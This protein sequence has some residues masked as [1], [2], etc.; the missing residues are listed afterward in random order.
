M[1]LYDSWTYTL[2]NSGHGVTGMVENG[3]LFAR[4]TYQ[5]YAL[6]VLSLVV[7]LWFVYYCFI[8]EICEY[9]DVRCITMI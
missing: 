5:S 6:F 1:L 4:G 8:T 2:Y 9:F 7:Y 3:S